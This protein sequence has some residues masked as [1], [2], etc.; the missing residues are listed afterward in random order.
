MTEMKLLDI[1]ILVGLVHL[2][3]AV[4]STVKQRPSAWAT[5]PRD[6]PMP[7]IGVPARLDRSF[8][9]FLETFGFFAA[10]I[11]A[12]IIQNKVGPL[13]WWGAVLYVVARI[14]YIP[15]YAGGMRYVRTLVW[16]ISMVGIVMV[17]IA[18]F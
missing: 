18:A 11:L 14:V 6:Q 13:S 2:L 9:N 4:L 7:L 8:W 15:L 17:L 12:V 3:I 16:T 1:A 10:A 5:G